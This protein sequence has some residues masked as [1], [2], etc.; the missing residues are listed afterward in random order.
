MKVGDE[1]HA[2]EVLLEK[3][4]VQKVFGFNDVDGGRRT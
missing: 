1:I 4:W 2:N 3:E